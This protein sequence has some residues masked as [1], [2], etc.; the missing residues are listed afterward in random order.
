VEIWFSATLQ[1]GATPTF[2]TDIPTPINRFSAYFAV[3]I[4]LV[5]HSDY[6]ELKLLKDHDAEDLEKLQLRLDPKT[7][8]I[9]NRRV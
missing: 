2:K 9:A 7:L 1:N 4:H 5:A 3:I 6:I 8:L